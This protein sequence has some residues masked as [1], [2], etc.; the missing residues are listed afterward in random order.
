MTD[1][2]TSPLKPPCYAVIFTS[3]D[4]GESQNN[5]AE[6]VIRLQEMAGDQP[7]YL[8]IED[9]RDPQGQD[10]TIS[11]WRDLEA[12]E[13]WQQVEQERDAQD[14]SR[15]KGQSTWYERYSIRVCRIEDTKD[16]KQESSG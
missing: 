8:G 7:G 11:Y 1:S 5:H 12:I 15:H 10:V 2:I 16:F 6:V 4:A 3:I 14:K 13:A 9:S